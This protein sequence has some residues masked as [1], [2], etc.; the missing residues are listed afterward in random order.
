M[1]PP[2]VTAAGGLVSPLP[3]KDLQ[4][5][6]VGRSAQWGLPHVAA[7]GET[8]FAVNREGPLGTGEQ[9]GQVRFLLGGP[10]LAELG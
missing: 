7:A 6:P 2:H 4:A 10:R 1:G 8:C 5:Q 9:R 3:T